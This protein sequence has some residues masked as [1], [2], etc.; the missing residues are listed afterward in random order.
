M[1][2]AKKE[3]KKVVTEAA[4]AIAAAIIAKE[5]TMYKETINLLD[6]RD[7]NALTIVMRSGHKIRIREDGETLRPNHASKG[8][9]EDGSPELKFF[10][11][12]RNNTP[13]AKEVRDRLW[14][15]AKGLEAPTSSEAKQYAEML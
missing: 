8:N 5:L 12:L 1:A 2:D 10:F 7:K 14:K 11:A 13:L 3:T 4:E 6:E 15:H 9:M